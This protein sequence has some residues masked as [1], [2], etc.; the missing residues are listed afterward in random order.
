L[1]VADDAGESQR[2]YLLAL[3]ARSR[4]DPA[5]RASFRAELPQIQRLVHAWLSPGAAGS[6]SQ[7]AKICANLLALE[8]ALWTFAAQPGV[9]PTNNATERALRR[10]VIWRRLSYGTHSAHGSQF[11]ER[12]LTTVESCRHQ[13]RDCLDFVRQAIM[14]HR[15]GQP[16]PSRFPDPCGILFV[17]P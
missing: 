16:A 9:E 3:W 11:V 12:I 15:A 5:Q 2:E 13:Q 1:L 10:P 14:A 6:D 8:P 4:D 7:T 17:T